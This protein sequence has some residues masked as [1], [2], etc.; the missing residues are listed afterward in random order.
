MES[1]RMVPPNKKKLTTA[2]MARTENLSRDEE[3]T[4]H[5]GADNEPID[6]HTDLHRA[7]QAAHDEKPSPLLAEDREKDFRAR[8]QSIQTEFVD[9]PRQ[10]V[11]K[12]DELVAEIMQQL[13]QSF[14]DQRSRL[15]SEWGHSER[16]STEDL[17]LALRRYRSFFDRLL[18][19]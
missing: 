1:T 3:F 14:S 10:A 9:E 15:E 16:A 17:R 7:P 2:D 13:A 5:H 6:T 11:E 19:F 4:D 12:A 8:W 18:S